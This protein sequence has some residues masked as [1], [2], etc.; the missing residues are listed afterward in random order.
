M[1]ALHRLSW[2][3]AARM[4]AALVALILVWAALE[5]FGPVRSQRIAS[6]T[7]DLMQR[8]RVWASAPDPRLL[9]V[10]I[11]ERS[12][13]DLSGEFGRW[14]WSRDTL[15][16]VLEAA[17]SQGA[18]AVVFDILF[19]D[20]DRVRPGGDVALDAAVRASRLGFFQ[21]VRLPAANDAGSELTLDRLSGLATPPATPSSAPTVAL[22]VPFMQSMLDSGH[23]GTDTVQL[24]FDGKLRRFAFA[25][26]L[27]GWVIA[28]MPLAVARALGAAGDDSG[29]P[30]LTVW[31]D[32]AGAYPRV[33][34]SQVFA[35][36]EQRARTACPDLRGK[37]LIVGA[38]APSLHDLMSSPLAINHPG[39]DILATL[40]DNALHARWYRELDTWLRFGLA[41]AAL[42]LAWTASRQRAVR[43]TEFALVGLP[44]VLLLLGYLSLHSEWLFL[45]LMLPAGMAIA[46]LSLVKGYDTARRFVF[47]LRRAPQAGRWALACG[48]AVRAAE[49]LER[50]V[51]D[52]GVRHGLGV[53]GGSRAAGSW[54]DAD[55]CWVLWEVAD[56]ATAAALEDDLRDA[57]PSAWTQ[58]FAVT[59]DADR[60]LHRAL[61]RRG[62][63]DTAPMLSN[64]A[65]DAPS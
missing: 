40:I 10:D 62:S 23:L 45:D 25:E 30:R 34:F 27:H 46:F 17:Q 48:C 18:L 42:G 36:A 55:A 61:S 21:V 1:K 47:G 8:H 12:L 24:D 20:P 15:A 57:F 7:F 13:A 11:D 59:Q 33:P 52:L 64:E 37:L 16:T 54:G 35:C 41:V 9:I 53:S 28:S 49:Q 2:P 5:S 4:H 38:T 3:S 31:R 63:P 14:P 58:L 22:I 56:P 39:V 50:H 26:R 32:A 19:S 43:A 6:A 51:F 60:D 65:P 29:A 44:I